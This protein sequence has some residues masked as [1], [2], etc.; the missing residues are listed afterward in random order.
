MRGGRGEV[1]GYLLRD[2]QHCY[3]FR[4]GWEEGEISRGI[5]RKALGLWLGCWK[6]GGGGGGKGGKGREWMA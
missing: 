3:D 5:W 4:N 6:K 1:F 2:S